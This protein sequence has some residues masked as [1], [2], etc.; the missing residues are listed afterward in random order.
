[1]ATPTVREVVSAAVSGGPATVVTGAGTQAN[2]LLV[3]FHG[4]NY[5]NIANWPGPPTGTAGTWTEQ[6]SGDAGADNA[7][8]KA[9][10][11]PVTVGGAQTVTV[12]PINNEETYQIT[13]VIVGDS[14]AVDDA[15]GSGSPTAT[16]SPVAPG[17]SPSGAD[18]LLLCAWQTGTPHTRVDFTAAAGMTDLT[19]VEDAAF[20]TLGSARQALTS[21]GPTGTRTATINAGRAY[22]A[23]TVAISATS[24]AAVVTGAAALSASAAMTVQ[25]RRVVRGAAAFTAHGTLAAAARARVRASTSMSATSALAAAARVV[26]R[27]AAA[28][29]GTSGAVVTGRVRVRA[30]AHLSGVSALTGAARVRVIAAAAMS[31]NG[32]LTA[33]AGGAVTGAVVLSAQTGLNA[34]ARVRALAAAPMSATGSLAA[35][36]VAVRLGAAALSAQATLTVRTGATSGAASLS[37]VASLVAAG[38]V[39]QLAAVQ[40]SGRSDLTAR[41]VVTVYAA[42][43]LQATASLVVAVASGGPARL[44]A[45][46][47]PSVELD[48]TASPLG[49]MSSSSV[50]LIRLEGR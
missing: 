48:A 11:R 15:A 30:S 12:A 8:L 23:V 43:H 19:E 47:R 14:L 29:S 26:V 33:S 28:L 45:S 44:S 24:G 32:S 35:R 46:S 5:Y 13:Y 2:D 3:T 22:A 4:S 1:M 38:L 50:P 31:G 40:A 6:A 25:A 41:G 34:A 21:S 49:V 20:S 10:S 42:A 16:T 37:A 27:A 36:G 39:R 17:A 7:H 18:D 9:F